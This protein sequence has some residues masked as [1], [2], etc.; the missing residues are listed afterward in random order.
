MTAA[1]GDWVAASQEHGEL[2][3]GSRMLTVV[4]EVEKKLGPVVRRRIVDTEQAPVYVYDFASSVQ[5]PAPTVA[6]GPRPAVRDAGWPVERA[7][8]ACDRCGKAVEFQLEDGEFVLR[9]ADGSTDCTPERG[10]RR[11][12]WVRR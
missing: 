12:H 4:R 5:R 9:G 1:P 11:I 7:V 6:I 10:M 3:A 2:A 8:Y